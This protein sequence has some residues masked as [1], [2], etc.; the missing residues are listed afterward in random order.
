[1]GPYGRPQI[2]ENK[3]PNKNWHF[4]FTVTFMKSEARHAFKT[5]KSS[6]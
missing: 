4:E 2:G 6:K 5:A 3:S 1:M